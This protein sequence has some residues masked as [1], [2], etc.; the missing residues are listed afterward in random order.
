MMPG[1]ARRRLPMFTGEGTFLAGAV[2]K[3]V[4]DEELGIPDGGA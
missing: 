4:C 1:P 3:P 2:S